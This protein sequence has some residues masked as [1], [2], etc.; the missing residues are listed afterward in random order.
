[1][2]NFITEQLGMGCSKGGFFTFYEILSSRKRK[3]AVGLGEGRRLSRCG[4]LLNRVVMRLRCVRFISA[5]V[6]PVLYPWDYELSVT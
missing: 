3:A 2:R 4:G 6:V 1:M 5:V